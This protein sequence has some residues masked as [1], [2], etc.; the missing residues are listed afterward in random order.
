[1]V[2]QQH[3]I[4][5]GYLLKVAALLVTAFEIMGKIYIVLHLITSTSYHDAFIL[6]ISKPFYL[7]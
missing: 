6:L 7:R 2:E 5:L 3:N 4:K 1:M